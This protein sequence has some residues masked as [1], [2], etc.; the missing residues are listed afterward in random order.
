LATIKAEIGWK[1]LGFEL[2]FLLILGWV[3]S[4]IV[5]QVGSLAGLG[6]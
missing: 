2:A 6:V 5:F 1:W 3:L 4:A